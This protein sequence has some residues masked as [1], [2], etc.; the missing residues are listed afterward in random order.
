MTNKL[1]LKCVFS[2]I[3]FASIFN[4]F[5]F[6]PVL[7]RAEFTKTFP[8]V[9]KDPTNSYFSD[10]NNLL[11]RG[12]VSGFSDGQFKPDRDLTRGEMSKFV[13]NA[14][15]GKDYKNESCPQFVDV[16]TNYT[17]YKEIRTL[18]CE[19]VVSGFG[20]GIFKPEDKVTRGEA[21][22][23]AIEGL[24]ASVDKPGFLSE[25]YFNQEKVLG[26]QVL[27]RDG[28]FDSFETKQRFS[29]VP[30]NTSF[31]TYSQIYDFSNL[32]DFDMKGVN[33]E[34]KPNQPILR[35]EMAQLIFRTLLLSNLKYSY[36]DDNFYSINTPFS[37]RKVGRL[38]FMDERY[39][40]PFPLG[41]SV[42]TKSDSNQRVYVVVMHKDFIFD[43]NWDFVNYD[44]TSNKKFTKDP[45]ETPTL[46]D[47]IECKNCDSIA[48][49]I[50]IEV[51]DF[52]VQVDWKKSFVLYG[53]DGSEYDM[54]TI[55]TGFYGDQE[56]QVEIQDKTENYIGQAKSQACNSKFSK[57][58]DVSNCKFNELYNEQDKTGYDKYIE[59]VK[60]TIFKIVEA[61]NAII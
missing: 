48:R 18:K 14:F 32:G 50:S 9:P 10:I 58:L 45:L 6:N 2:S 46:S 22:K 56:I 12:V 7:V 27:L 34:L 26:G 31:Y 33:S 61:D 28:K 29:D 15:F 39:Y 23:F 4:F 43:Q 5:L 41:A 30:A 36:K 38:E 17:F 19:G 35:K 47:Y 13:I 53:V 3:I 55:I 60:N 51:A 37:S 49:E 11:E 20:N 57:Q 25:K 42:Y 44:K 21:L 59:S 52:N 8:D 16:A 1:P 24:K 54:R 40:Q